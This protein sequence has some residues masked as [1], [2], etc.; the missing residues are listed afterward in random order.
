[1]TLLGDGAL[2][3]VDGVA[4]G[5]CPTRVTVDSGA[6]AIV[7]TFPP[8]GESKGESLTL[9]GGERVTLRA[10]FTGATPSIRT[11]GR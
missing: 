10:D 4:R 5:P 6:H 7:F 2:V 8:T 3:S 1:V 9:R 11:Q